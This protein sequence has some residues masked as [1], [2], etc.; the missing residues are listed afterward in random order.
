MLNFLLITSSVFNIALQ[1]F[2]N[3]S[4]YVGR[5][6][7]LVDFQIKILQQKSEKTKVEKADVPILKSKAEQVSNAM[8]M[9]LVGFR[10]ISVVS[11]YVR[12]TN[13]RKAEVRSLTDS[14]KYGQ[15]YMWFENDKLVMN[16]Y[17]SKKMKSS[18]SGTK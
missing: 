3:I 12:L 4:L 7:D 17:H 9:K 15:I 14:K 13:S 2:H 1:E 10:I 5:V 18:S 11:K 6:S 16:D 8:E